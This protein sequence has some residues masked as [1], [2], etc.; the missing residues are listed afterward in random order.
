MKIP[1]L[2]VYGT[3]RSG[4]R[5]TWKVDGYDLFFP[6]HRRFPVAMLNKGSKDMVVEVLNVDE[7]DIANYDI[8]E[9]IDSGLYERRIVRAY[10]DKEEVEAWMYTVGTLLLQNTNVFQKVPDKDWFSEK[11]QKLIAST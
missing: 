8:Y 4:N 9:G 10:N 2:A 7:Q 3:L 1:K 11:C 6:G 5:D